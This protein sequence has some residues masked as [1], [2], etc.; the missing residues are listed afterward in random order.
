MRVDLFVLAIAG[1][2]AKRN[3]QL[4]LLDSGPSMFNCEYLVSEHFLI[5]FGVTSVVYWVGEWVGRN[6]S[7]KINGK[8]LAMTSKYHSEV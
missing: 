8:A 4:R 5:R 7:H 6:H 3:R 1:R 2:A